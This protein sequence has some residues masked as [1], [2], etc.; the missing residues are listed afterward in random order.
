MLCEKNSVKSKLIETADEAHVIPIKLFT[1][2]T[3]PHMAWHRVRHWL[4]ELGKVII[5]RANPDLHKTSNLLVKNCG[6]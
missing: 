1:K 2:G 5:A 3:V 6:I 4:I